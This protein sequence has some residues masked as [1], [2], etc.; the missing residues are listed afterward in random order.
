M[1]VIDL[2][3]EKYL[4]ADKSPVRAGEMVEIFYNPTPSEMREIQ[5]SYGMGAIRFIA[6][7]RTKKIYMWNAELML[8]LQAWMKIKS[9]VGDNRR[10]YSTF[11][12][13]SGEYYKDGSYDWYSMTLNDQDDLTLM[14]V[15]DWSW[16]DKFIKGMEKAAKDEMKLRIW[17]ENKAKLRKQGFDI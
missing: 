4:T 16:T 10:L 15:A 17:A 14:Y 6:D 12:L 13:M 8:H 7:D 9:E 11:T 1:V 3:L 5:R 2:V